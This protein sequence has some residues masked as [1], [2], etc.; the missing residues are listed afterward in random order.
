MADTHP[1]TSAP[2][3][4]LRE[5]TLPHNLEAEAAVLGCIFL[6]PVNALEIAS[7][8][9]NFDGSFYRPA[10]QLI[11]SQLL[12]ISNS[13]SAAHIDLIHFADV[14]DKEGS[15]E[16]IGGRA[17]LSQ[18]MN[19][20][21]TAANVELYVDIVHQNAIL[22]RLISTCVGTIDKCFDSV[23]DVHALLDTI[24]TEVLSVT[25]LTQTGKLRTLRDLVITAVEHVEKLLHGDTEALGI[26]TGFDDLDRLITGLKPGEMFV[27]AARPSIGKTALALNMAAYIAFGDRHLPVGIF[28][29]EMP[30]EQLVLRLLSS[31]ARIGLRE[32]R[33]GAL[34]NTRWQEIMNAS[35][36]LREA[37]VVIDDTGAIDVLELRAKA[38]RMKRDHHIEALFIDYLQLL[39]VDANRNAS[40]ENEV[41]KMS[42]AIKAL[43][44]E[45][46]IPIVVL[47]QLNRQ[48]EQPGQ[49]PRLAH[50][51]ESGAIEQDADVVALLHRDRDAQLDVEA[52]QRGVEAE[53]I[54]AKNRNG[55]TGLVPLTF[56]P[57]YTRFES[58]SRISDDDIPE[59]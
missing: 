17:Y 37:E 15:L 44:K 43:A 40:R 36:R 35:Q 42:G 46:H 30:A 26:S 59:V 31:E 54:V 41:S 4:D 55:E 13:S 38:R 52:V 12:A 9:L 56:L 33:E 45:L 34:S 51:R 39:H 5:R 25:G 28:S 23:D 1:V 49:R 2:V 58:R 20:V 27:L 48:A 3:V 18:L 22:R 16:Q 14:L 32:I 57:A 10:H 19:S 11:F 47:A 8:K 21:P 24:E 50:L 53:L 7:T 6:D 29:L